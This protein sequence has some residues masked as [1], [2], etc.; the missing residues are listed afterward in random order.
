MSTLLVTRSRRTLALICLILS[1][2]TITWYL[3]DTELDPVME[4]YTTVV[5]VVAFNI[6]E[7]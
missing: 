1:I 3:E 2:A 7:K 6:L 4:N 5:E